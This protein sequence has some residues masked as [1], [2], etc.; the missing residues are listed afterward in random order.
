VLVLVLDLWTRGATKADFPAI[1]LFA[2]RHGGISSFS[3]T[4]TRTSPLTSE[5]RLNGRRINEE[6]AGRL[7]SPGRRVDEL[8][9]GQVRSKIELTCPYFSLCNSNSF[10]VTVSS[11][12]IP[13]WF[14][15]IRKW[16]HAAGR[17]TP[18]VPQVRRS[19]D[20]S[21][22]TAKPKVRDNGIRIEYK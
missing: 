7:Q 13:F 12:Q 4:T 5:F 10:S 11:S 3:S 20:R 15:R 8:E 16:P 21:D 14:G 18:R 9:E 19:G 2:R 1:N 22:R 6:H 17:G